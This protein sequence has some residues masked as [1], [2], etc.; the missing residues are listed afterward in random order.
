MLSLL[1][2]ENTGDKLGKINLFKTSPQNFTS[3]QLNRIKAASAKLYADSNGV[4]EWIL[5]DQPGT[6]NPSV[7]TAAPTTTAAPV[8]G[9]T[10]RR[11][12]G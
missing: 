1:L 4:Y 3:A 9:T 6:V 2:V 7:T 10:T 12:I 5:T 8:I 11:P